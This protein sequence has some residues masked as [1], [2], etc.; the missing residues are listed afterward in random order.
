MN[1]GAGFW[2]FLLLIVLAF[3]L[4]VVVWAAVRNMFGPRS[5]WRG[6]MELRER[7]RQE[8]RRLQVDP[9]QEAGR[10]LSGGD[11]RGE[12]GGDDGPGAGGAP[13]PRGGGDPDDEPRE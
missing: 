11:A 8:K 10:R 4:L 13:P 5:Q 9:W 7:I 1:V 6:E 3:G 12:A 2:L